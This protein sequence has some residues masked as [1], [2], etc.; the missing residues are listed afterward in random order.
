MQDICKIKKGGI[1]M[2]TIDSKALKKAMIDADCDTYGQ[3]S[4]KTGINRMTLSAYLSGE[5]KPTYEYIG[6]LADF[7]NLTYE[8]IGAI[9]FRLDVATLK[10]K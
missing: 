4:E 7:L 2:R 9:F 3:L 10:G 1:K 6:I 5:R 8:E